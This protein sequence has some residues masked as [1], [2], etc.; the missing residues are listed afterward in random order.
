MQ[1]SDPERQSRA[2]GYT[3]PNSCPEMRFPGNPDAQTCWGSD[4]LWC[5]GWSSM[6]SWGRWI[7]ANCESCIPRGG[8][9][10]PPVPSCP[11]LND[12]ECDDG[13]PGSQFNVC[14][15]TTGDEPD[16]GRGC[17]QLHQLCTPHH[18]GARRDSDCQCAGLTIPS[19]AGRDRVC[20]G[21]Y[22]EGSISLHYTC[23]EPAP[24]VAPRC[25]TREQTCHSN[26]VNAEFKCCAGLT[27]ATQ[28][29]G[30]QG[31]CCPNGSTQT[32]EPEACWTTCI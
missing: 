9:A 5:S 3:V 18:G 26:A 14:K 28:H 20:F 17:K 23:S 32:C 22:I 19:G 7:C 8:S 13:G 4:G 27:C 10:K 1:D 2:S 16:C 25:N 6:S 21:E 11:Y 24:P 30:W 12:N 29:G 31:I 15:D